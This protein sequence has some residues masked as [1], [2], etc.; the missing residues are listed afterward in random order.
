M[1]VLTVLWHFLESDMLKINL[2]V[3]FKVWVSAMVFSGQGKWWH[4]NLKSWQSADEVHTRHSNQQAILA[5]RFQRAK[6]VF[7]QKIQQSSIL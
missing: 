5:V 4:M 6:C 3:A 7:S 2:L 1:T